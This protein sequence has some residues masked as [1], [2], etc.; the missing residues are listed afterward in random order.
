MCVSTTLWPNLFHN[1]ILHAL[2]YTSETWAT[3]KKEEQRVP[4][5]GSGTQTV[6][7]KSV[8]GISVQEYIQNEIFF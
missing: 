1:T 6:M 4:L 8:L 5:T 7:E 2:L 3:I